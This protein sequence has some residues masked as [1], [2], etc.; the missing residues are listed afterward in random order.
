MISGIF[1]QALLARYFESWVCVTAIVQGFFH[2]NCWSLQLTAWTP[3]SSIPRVSWVVLRCS[4]PRA[5]ELPWIEREIVDSA[6]GGGGSVLTQRRE[7]CITFA[8]LVGNGYTFDNTIEKSTVYWYVYCTAVE[9]CWHVVPSTW[10]YSA[11]SECLLSVEYL[12]PGRVLQ[13]PV[14]IVSLKTVYWILEFTPT[15]VV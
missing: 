3:T 11:W 10:S 2:H 1:L 12:V 14:Y 4:R 15:E 13:S 8:T 6:G 5:P 7:K 9:H